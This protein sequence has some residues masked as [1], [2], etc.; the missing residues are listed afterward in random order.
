MQIGRFSRLTGLTWIRRRL[1][2]LIDE[3]ETP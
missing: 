3:K 2:S 1:Q